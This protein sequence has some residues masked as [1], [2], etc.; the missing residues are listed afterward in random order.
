MN[1]T[2]I[3]T[4]VIVLLLSLQVWTAMGRLQEWNMQNSPEPVYGHS[5]IMSHQSPSQMFLFGGWPA[6]TLDLVMNQ[7]RIFDFDSW[8]WHFAALGSA[9]T[10]TDGDEDQRFPLNRHYHAMAG[11]GGKWIL[12]GGYSGMQYLDSVWLFDEAEFR[13][14]RVNMTSDCFDMTSA[15]SSC[16]PTPR[17][18][19]S[20][21]ALPSSTG[22][23]SLVELVMFGGRSGDR[24]LNDMYLM[25]VNLSSVDNNGVYMGSWKRIDAAS[26]PSQRAFHTATLIGDFVYVFGG[27]GNGIDPVDDLSVHIYSVSKRQWQNAINTLSSYIQS[28]KSVWGHSAQAVTVN[29]QTFIVFVGG[30]ASSFSPYIFTLSI[31]L[32]NNN[33]WNIVELEQLSDGNASSD[34]VAR[35][36]PSLSPFIDESG[37]QFLV[38]FAGTT[39]S[40]TNDLDMIK[41]SKRLQYTQDGY[42]FPNLQ[43]VTAHVTSAVMTPV[44]KFKKFVV[45]DGWGFNQQDSTLNLVQM[46]P[47]SDA[48]D[49]MSVPR[50][51][52]ASDCFVESISE[53]QI[54]C[55]TAFEPAGNYLIS[56]QMRNVNGVLMSESTHIQYECE[57]N[58]E[59]TSI[60]IGVKNKF[61]CIKKARI[62]KVA[63]LH[64]HAGSILTMTGAN[65]D[66]YSVS[67]MIDGEHCQNIVPKDDTLTELKCVL[68]STPARRNVDLAIIQT[69]SAR[70]E[71]GQSLS[72][73][74]NPSTSEQLKFTFDLNVQ[75]ISLNYTARSLTLFGEGFGDGQSFTDAIDI[76]IVSATGEVK[77]ASICQVQTYGSSEIKCLYNYLDIRNSS[78]IEIAVLAIRQST[79]SYPEVR[80]TGTLCANDQLLAVLNNTFGAMNGTMCQTTTIEKVEHD[81]DIVGSGQVVLVT[82]SSSV[83]S[84]TISRATATSMPPFIVRPIMAQVPQNDPVLWYTMMPVSI[85]LGTIVLTLV[86]IMSI[87][88]HRRKKQAHRSEEEKLKL[89]RHEL[90]SAWDIAGRGS[91]CGEN[92]PTLCSSVRS[93]FSVA[94]TQTDVST[95]TDD[96]L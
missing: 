45:I 3:V 72:T 20:L 5:S 15:A 41:I 58:E 63:P 23:G 11:Q 19:H 54:S 92:L 69:V 47:L 17:A 36:N 25:T 87:I 68:G 38:E 60:P 67:M 44:D 39:A 61:A 65:L 57:S 7:T 51:D 35:R 42:P 12:Y 81:D 33:K 91:F 83:I 56:L 71:D 95:S 28:T 43:S 80:I 18:G 1:L 88:T 74:I 52:R 94:S 85:V 55:Y 90:E 62:D 86:V 73:K 4:S 66:P 31:D 37:Q 30:Y 29:E 21:V 96:R 10:S 2:I 84:K 16:H 34:V 82:S 9:I 78:R 40:P 27:T 93:S 70:L 13:W 64:G 48:N 24:F 89:I 50:Q 22:D 49:Q 59:Y 26:P 8:Q 46:I 53:T 32:A 77:S 79:S 14:F 6:D 76:E 75:A